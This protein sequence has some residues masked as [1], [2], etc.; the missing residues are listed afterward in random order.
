M[1]HFHSR[2]PVEILQDIFLLKKR[3]DKG[4]AIEIPLITFMLA[5]KQMLSGFLMDFKKDNRDAY[6][7][8][9]ELEGSGNIFFA[10]TYYIQGVVVH[11][12]ER[13]D[14]LLTEIN[15]DKISG[16]T[17]S[18][19]DIK[20]KLSEETQR[21]TAYFGKPITIQWEEAQTE[22]KDFYFVKNLIVDTSM[23]LLAVGESEPG[24]STIAESVEKIMLQKGE[25]LQVKLEGKAMSIVDTFS[26]SYSTNL[27]RSN[28]QQALVDVL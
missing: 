4:E 14:Y 7:L 2:P 15:A 26:R 13:I 21:L 24:K 16:R 18:K 28:L 8:S 20:N 17:A 3:K 6:H 22:T 9:I 1:Q 27:Q 11:D 5:N 10:E 19:L 23:S 12:I 25:S